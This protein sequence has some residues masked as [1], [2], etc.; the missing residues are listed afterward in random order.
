MLTGQRHCDN[1]VIPLF[2]QMGNVYI[3]HAHGIRT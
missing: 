1:M 2:E 3:M